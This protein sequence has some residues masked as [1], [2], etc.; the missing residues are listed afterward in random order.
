M[1]E[2]T[3]HG[4]ALRDV[5]LT[6]QTYYTRDDGSCRVEE[7]TVPLPGAASPER[8]REA[9]FGSIRWVHGI[10]VNTVPEA[11]LTEGAVGLVVGDDR[12]LPDLRVDTLMVWRLS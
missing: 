2:S 10:H 4:R 7:A 1:E 3:N 9:H 6:V 11:L 12:Q 5:T 8:A